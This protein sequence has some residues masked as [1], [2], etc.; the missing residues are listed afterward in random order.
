MLAEDV[1]LRQLDP[2]DAAAVAEAYARNR[3]H[4]A[5][6]EPTREPSWATAEVQLREAAT[7]LRA[8]ARGDGIPLVLVR[9]EDVVG[10][11]NVTG[12]IRGSFLSANLGYWLDAALAGRGLM[13]TAVRIACEVARDELAL[14]RL[15]AGTLLHNAASQHVLRACGFTPIGVA[16]RYL[17][18]A[19]RWQDHLLFQRILT[20]E[21]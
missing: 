15:Q 2:A 17:R 7:R 6:W 18:I 10:V 21:E 9:G 13:S 19:G 14:H 1:V 11:L 4:L 20:D 3:E 8:H 12:T 5:P 16:P